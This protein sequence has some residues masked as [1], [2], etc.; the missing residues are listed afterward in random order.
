MTARAG[1]ALA[2][3]ALALGGCSAASAPRNAEAVRAMYRSIG[4]DASSGYWT[5]ICSSY[6]DASLR[7]QVQRRAKDCFSTTVE[8]WA[9][10]IRLAKVRPSTRIVLSGGRATIFDGPTP[11]V[12]LYTG[13]QWRL[14]RAAEITG[15]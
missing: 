15:G 5:D 11:E 14:D 8:R 7:A 13:G 9:E 4:V 2:L 6:M 12:A 10:R 3:C 1:V